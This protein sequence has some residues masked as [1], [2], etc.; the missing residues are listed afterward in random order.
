MLNLLMEVLNDQAC[1]MAFPQKDDWEPCIICEM[2]S[3]NPTTDPQ[4]SSLLR[5]RLLDV[6]QSS[7]QRNG[8][9]N[10][11]HIPFPLFREHEVIS[12]FTNHAS[13]F[14]IERTNHVTV[15][16][17][18]V[19]LP[20]EFGIEVVRHRRECLW[21]KLP[22]KSKAVLSASFVHQLLSRITKF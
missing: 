17:D 11:H 19:N 9:L 14:A 6:T 5:S 7:P 13:L 8:C 3:L 22:K 15:F 10:P 4:H 1:F 16:Y 2:S 20:R 18:C 21:M 12:E